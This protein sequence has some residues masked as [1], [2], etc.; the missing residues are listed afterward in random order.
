MDCNI[1]IVRALW[2]TLS[3]EFGRNVTNEVYFSTNGGNPTA[4]SATQCLSLRLITFDSLHH[5]RNSVYLSI[6]ATTVY[7]L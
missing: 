6:S 3:M 1:Y 2:L 5:G 7:M 4:R